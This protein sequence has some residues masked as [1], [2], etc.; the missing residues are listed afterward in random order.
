M[1]Y[2]RRVAEKTDLSEAPRTASLL[3][4]SIALLVVGTIAAAWTWGPI[5]ATLVDE[6]YTQRIYPLV[7]ATLISATDW[8]SV[9]VGLATALLVAVAVLWRAGAAWGRAARNDVP[10]RRRVF[11]AALRA[12]LVACLVYL[13][14]VL[15]WGAGYRRT[16]IGVTLEFSDQ[17]LQGADVERLAEKC[18]DVIDRTG[19]GSGPS[20]DLHEEIAAI[21]GAMR[22]LVQRQ[23]GFDPPL[24]TRVKRL[25][26][27]SLL[28]FGT[29]GT[30][31]PFSLEAHVD[32]ALPD[33]SALAVSAHELAHT[34][35]FNG[36]AEA[37][38]IGILSAWRADAPFA[39][40]AAALSVFRRAVAALPQ[41]KRA[42][43]MA[44]LPSRAK[45]D[46]AALRAAVARHVVEF[47]ATPQRVIYDFFLRSQGVTAG[48]AD[49]SRALRLAIEA[50]RVGL[51]VNAPDIISEDMK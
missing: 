9:P 1:I 24:P 18:L 15:V 44:R 34:A 41:T 5:P 7:A 8:T 43:F 42:D 16:P 12:T 32:Q 26:A 31:F 23:F 33:A 49:Y 39:R 40:Y 4:E 35:G 51:F 36:E 6:W 38:L 48:V 46:I 29:G 19:K 27:G 28:G 30:I 20:P 10:R 50:D 2:D 22:A 37:E 21:R 13:L 47:L 11:R 3:L 45:E 17:P 25:P 14:F